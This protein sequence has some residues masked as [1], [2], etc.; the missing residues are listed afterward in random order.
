MAF[1]E[2][3]RFVERIDTASGFVTMSLAGTLVDLF[4]NLSGEKIA[5]YTA[6]ENGYVLASVL[7]RRG[8]Q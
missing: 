2:P 4:P 1:G 3:E 6:R 8:D 7:G 5:A